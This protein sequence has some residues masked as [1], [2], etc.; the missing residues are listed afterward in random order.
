MSTSRSV[1]SSAS[2]PPGLSRTPT[3]S[4]PPEALAK[5]AVASAR[6]FSAS[7]RDRPCRLKSNVRDSRLSADSPATTRARASSASVTEFHLPFA[8]TFTVQGR[9]K[10]IGEPRPVG[11]SAAG[12]AESLQGRLG[13]P[14][15][16]RRCTTH[17]SVTSVSVNVV[18][19]LP[20]SLAAAQQAP[21]CCTCRTS[22]AGD[23]KLRQQCASDQGKPENGW[24]RGDSNP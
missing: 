8:Q 9:A 1:P 24:R 20:Q 19:H 7:S 11:P 14:C 23:H 21:R 13:T 6:L 12:C 5:H 17:S 2:G 18:E 22:A 4:V 15:F 10:R 3:T 16:G